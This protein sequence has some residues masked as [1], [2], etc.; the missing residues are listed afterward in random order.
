MKRFGANPAIN[1]S[2]GIDQARFA[3]PFIDLYFRSMRFRVT[4]I[5]QGLVPAVR[6]LGAGGSSVHCVV[7]YAGGDSQEI[8]LIRTR[9][10]SIF[11][12][13]AELSV[14]FAA[15]IALAVGLMGLR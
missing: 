1:R 5:F 6:R 15:A 7:S 9:I 12:Q 2:R 13:V 8:P 14:F 4:S 3:W 10:V 11:S